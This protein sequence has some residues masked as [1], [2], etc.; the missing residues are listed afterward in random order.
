MARAYDYALTHFNNNEGWRLFNFDIVKLGQLVKNDRTLQL[1]ETPVTFPD[2][3]VGLRWVHVA[4]QLNLLCDAIADT[5]FTAEEL[6]QHFEEI[7][8]FTDGNG[9]VGA[10]LYNCYNRT[11]EDP[12]H[13]PE[14]KKVR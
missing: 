2:G 10:I 4:R 8:P 9:R 7:H 6:Y 12:I 5:D 3:S 1:R 14:F 13:P 11:L